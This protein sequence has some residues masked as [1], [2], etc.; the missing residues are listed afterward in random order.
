MTYFKTYI[1]ISVL[2]LFLISCKNKDVDNVRAKEIKEELQNEK[3]EIKTENLNII[4]ENEKVRY[5][6]YVKESF[7]NQP[8]KSIMS[9]VSFKNI[10]LKYDEYLK[11]EKYLQNSFNEKETDTIITYDNKTNSFVFIKANNKCFFVQSVISDSLVLQ[12]N[13]KVGLSRKDFLKKFKIE[14]DNNDII[15]FTNE[16]DFSN[17]LFHFEKDKLNKIRINNNYN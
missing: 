12:E 1:Y 13:V 17:I 16:E 8:F 3:E 5:N 11:T 6:T 9:C 2:S 4:T 10:V 14:N 7:V 15:K